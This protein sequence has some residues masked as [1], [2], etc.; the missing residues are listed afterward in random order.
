MGKQ[1]IAVLR[2]EDGDHFVEQERIGDN[3][4]RWG[5]RKRGWKEIPALCA[6]GLRPR[7]V[8]VAK[9]MQIERNMLPQ[10]LPKWP[11][12]LSRELV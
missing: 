5:F 10:E 7:L 12:R 6:S 8:R 1:N 9:A 2:D 4:R 3:R 11:V